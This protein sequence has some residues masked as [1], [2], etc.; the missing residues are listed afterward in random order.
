MMYAP[1][2]RS[3][4]AASISR[5]ICTPSLRASGAGAGL[6]H[7]LAD[8]LGDLHAGHLV[9]EEL[10]V[11][12]A[13]ERQEADQHR[14]AERRDVV[15]EPLEHA[16]VVD[17]L[18]HHE[19]GAGRL[20]LLE[21]RELACRDRRRPARPGREQERRR[22]AAERLAAGIDAAV[23]ARRRAAAGRSSRGRRPRVAS[24][25]SPIFGGSPV[26]MTRLLHA[27]RV[28]AEQVRDLAE[29]V[30]IAPADVEDRLDAVARCEQ[31]RA[32]GEVR[33]ARHG[34]RRRRRC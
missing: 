31:Q 4:T 12:V 20:L 21:A 18:G 34:A 3:R 5:A 11:A 1:C 26:M 30:P 6:A 14:Q 28:R 16:R 23:D 2:T 7:P 33:H 8:R 25:K 15:E 32:E 13:R 9:V 27:E 17:R 22:A 19:L 29:Q 24:G 10:G